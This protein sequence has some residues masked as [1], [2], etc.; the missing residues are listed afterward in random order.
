MVMNQYVKTAIKDFSLGLARLESTFSH[1]R[2]ELASNRITLLDTA[3]NTENCGDQIIMHYADKNL[4]ELFPGAVRQEHV[5]THGYSSTLEHVPASTLKIACGTNMIATDMAGFGQL[6]TPILNLRSYRHSVCLLAV[7]MRSLTDIDAPF[8]KYSRDFL[9]FVLTPDVMHSVRDENTKKKLAEIGIKNVI[10]T[11]CVTM[12]GLTPEF[13]A[14][15][16]KQKH[17]EVLTTVT[18]YAR[19]PESDRFMLETLLQEYDR[20]HLWVQAEEDREYVAQLIDAGSIDYIE[21]SKD[22]L[23]RFLADNADHLDYFG[24]RLHAG[25]HSLN[26]GLRAMIVEVD[27]RARDIA[28]DTNLPVVTRKELKQAMVPLIREPRATEIHIPLDR[29]NQWK[30]QFIHWGESR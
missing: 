3:I 24:T 12:W 2:K 16:P 29:I 18:N 30:S 20:V 15:L 13:C 10:N 27:N 11:S 19:D 23:D 5:Q 17:T 14:A 21:H 9:R 26:Q 25:V 4:K 28:A 8:T 22:A 1:D 7:G 6:M